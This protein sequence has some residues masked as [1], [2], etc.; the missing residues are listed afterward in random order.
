VASGAT[1]YAVWS[2]VRI[3]NG[4]DVGQLIGQKINLANSGTITFSGAV[5]TGSAAGNWNVKYYEQTF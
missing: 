2:Q 1:F 3:N 5:V 4:T